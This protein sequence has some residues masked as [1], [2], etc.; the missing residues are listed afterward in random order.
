MAFEWHVV[1][2]TGVVPL[3][4]SYYTE[5]DMGFW[6]KPIW[7]PKWEILMVSNFLYL[8]ICQNIKMWKMT[9]LR[10]L[11]FMKLKSELWIPLWWF[12]QIFAQT[13]YLLT[14]SVYFYKN[15]SCTS[16]SFPSL[17]HSL[18]SFTHPFINSPFSLSLIKNALFLINISFHLVLIMS[19]ISLWISVPLI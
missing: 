16:L 9:I 14:G 11:N 8:E 3:R 18:I 17:L 2:P 15:I 6:C 10:L 7:M 13:F 4:H 19:S 12:H 5:H 1:A